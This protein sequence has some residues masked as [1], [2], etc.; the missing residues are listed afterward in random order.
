MTFQDSRR[1]RS[2][3]QVTPPRIRVRVLHVIARSQRV[4][5][6]VAAPMTGSATKP[7]QCR[8]A[9]IFADDARY[10]ELDCF[11]SLAMTKRDHNEQKGSGTPTSAFVQPPHHRMR[12]ASSGTRSFA[13]WA[14]LQA[15]LP[16][17]WR[18]RIVLSSS[19]QPGGERL[20]AAKRALPAPA[21]PSPGNAPP[22]PVVMPVSMMSKAARV[23]TANPRAGTALAPR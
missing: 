17:T 3:W 1:S 21:C 2:T 10:T 8:A 12:R 4:R 16:G 15:T 13:P 14:Q 6:E 20:S 9:D 11:A 19:P 18:E 22:G 7:I 5:P 23:R